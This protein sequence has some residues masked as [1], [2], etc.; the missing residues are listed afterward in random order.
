[1]DFSKLE[2]KTPKIAD[3]IVNKELCLGMVKLILEGGI[4]MDGIKAKLENIKNKGALGAFQGL[5]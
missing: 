1:M 4:G 2:F 5:G 3:D